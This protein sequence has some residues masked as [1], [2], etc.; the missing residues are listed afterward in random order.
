[1]T[2]DVEVAGR[3]THVHV[4]DSSEIKSFLQYFFSS[5]DAVRKAKEAHYITNLANTLEPN[6]LNKHD[7]TF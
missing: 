1:M 4:I 3:R 2:S 5:H 7:E 6:E